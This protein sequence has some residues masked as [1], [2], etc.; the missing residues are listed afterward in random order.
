MRIAMIG[1]RGLP[2]HVGGVERVVQELARELASLGHE[3]IVYSRRHYSASGA[4]VDFCRVVHTPGAAGKH[5]DT[6]THTATAMFDVLRR[7]VDVVHVHSPGP[8]LLS[9]IP[10]LARRPVVLTIHAPDWRRARWSP[11]ARWMIRR[12]LACG[13]RTA[14]AVTCVSR[15]LAEEL[16][17]RF[18]R[19]VVHV[20]NAARPVRPAPPHLIRRWNLTPGKYVLYVGRIV[21]EKRLDLLL[22]A[23]KM[24]DIRRNLVIVGEAGEGRYARQCQGR[25]GPSAR[26]VGRQAGQALAEL[27]TNSALVA[28]PSS[29]EGMSLVLL[30]AAAYQRCVLAADIPDNRACMGDSIVYFQRDDVEDLAAKLRQLLSSEDLRRSLGSRAHAYVR[31]RYSWRKSARAMEDVYAG[32]RMTD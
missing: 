6:L 14:A 24:L 17:R 2:A 4:G 1:S 9:W 28:Q 12:G 25:A 29:L 3:I 8:A 19:A 27:Y 21:P 22:S 11:A 15:P 7:R 5:L 30:E 31:E 13:M 20:P 26:F 32:A 18:A 10:A 23:W 16:S